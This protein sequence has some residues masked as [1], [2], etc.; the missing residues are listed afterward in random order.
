MS[1]EFVLHVDSCSVAQSRPQSHVTR[2]G[3]AKASEDQ[4][5]CMNKV[6]TVDLQRDGDA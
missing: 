2:C 1:I 4:T 3:S 6:I 5:I